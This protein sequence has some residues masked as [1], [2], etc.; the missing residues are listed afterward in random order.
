MAGTYTIDAWPLEIDNDDVVTVD[1]YSSNPQDS[2]WIGVYSPYSADITATTPAKYAYCNEDNDYLSSGMGSLHFNMTNLRSDLAFYFFSNGTHYPINEAIAPRVSFKNYNQALRARVTPT[3]NVDDLL[4]SWSSANSSAPMLRWGAGSGVYSH[5]VS[6]STYTLAQSQML[7][8]PAATFGWHDLGQI[9]RAV[10]SGMR[11]LANT[12]VYYTFGDAATD[13]WSPEH[14]LHVPPSPGQQP[15]TR[16]TTIVLFQDLGTGSLDDA[17]T[18]KDKGQPPVNTS[19]RIAAE[20]AD[21][22]VDAVFHGGDISYADGYLTTWDFFLDMISPMAS[23]VV[24]LTTV[25]NHESDCPGTASI[26][27]GN[28]SGGECGLVSG[29]LIPLPPPATL[30]EPW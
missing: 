18:K 11:A 3:G 10:F 1:Y 17:R 4:L 2:D 8:T 16:P 7:G 22:S 30:D 19:M 13:T 9:H 24:Y 20:I 6:A 27:D 12:R 26:F 15:P 29:E 23:S 21:G 14:I 28:D 25:G 5:N